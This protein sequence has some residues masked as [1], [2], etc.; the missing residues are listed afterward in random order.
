M[1][2]LGLP[3]LEVL[4]HYMNLQITKKQVKEF[5]MCFR[6]TKKQSTNNS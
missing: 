2:T 4:F 1:R 5:F 3:V 6:Q